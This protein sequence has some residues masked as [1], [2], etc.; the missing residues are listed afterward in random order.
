MTLKIANAPCSWGVDY[1]EDKNNPDFKKYTRFISSKK[2]ET[3]SHK[4]MKKCQKH[5]KIDSDENLSSRITLL[6]HKNMKTNK[7]TSK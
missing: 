4:N 6:D 7:N 5:V 2:C 3:K 1:A